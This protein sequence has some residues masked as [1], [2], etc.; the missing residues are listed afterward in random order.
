MASGDRINVGNAYVTIIP[1]LEGAQQS[2][3]EQLGA[4][5]GAAA[6]SVGEQS[7]QDFGNALATGIK[8]TAAVVAAATAAVAG[9]AIATGKAFIQAANDVSEWGNT[10]DKESQKMNMTAEGYQTWAFILEHAG[11]SID[12]MK[13]AMKKLTIAAEEGNDAFDALG[14]SEEQLAAMSPEETWNATIEALQNVADEGERTALAN[15]LLGKGA[16]ELAP[17]FNMTA[18]ETDELK[19][20]VKELG[21]IMS[22]DAVKAAAEYQD[23]LQNMNVALDGVKNN[24][25][26]KFLPGMSQVMKGLSMVFSGQ[27]GIEEIKAGLGE[28]TANIV[29][30]SPEFFEIASAIVT[31]VL[32]GFGAMLPVAASSIFG[33]ISDALVTVTG[34]LPSLLPV[35]TTGISTLMSTVLDCLPLITSSL[36]TLV[37][38]L[39]TWL[40]S[41][42]NVKLLVDGIV[43]LVGA[44]VSQ[45][46]LVLPV[47]L[48]AVVSIIGD[49][50]KCL[51]TPENLAIL[52]NAVLLCVGA[53]IQALVNVVP[54]FIDYY[55]G[56]V[57]NIADVIIG[58]TNWVEPYVSQGL[59]Y[60]LGLFNSWGS[61][62][63]SFFS[64]IVSTITSTVSNWVGNISATISNGIS[65]IYN[66]V[67]GWVGNIKAAIVNFTIGVYNTVTGWIYDIQNGFINGFNSITS[68]VG[69]ILGSIGQFVGD[70]VSTLSSLPGQIVSIGSDMAEG[71]INGLDV[72]WVVEQVKKLGKKAIKALK[73]TLGIASPSKEFEKIGY[74][75]ALGFGGGWSDEMDIIADDMVDGMTDLT[76]SMSAE[77]TAY[78]AGGAATIGDTTTYNGGAV[79][80]NIYGAEGQDVN[81]L[82]DV[83]AEKLGDMTARK[84]AVYA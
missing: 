42:N 38:D 69:N 45:I 16:V 51:T 54:E 15:E 32:E 24:M 33:F 65:G 26:S 64:G 70:V 47:L 58:F 37:T 41:G 43:K 67:T 12:G 62:I 57:T 30:L 36:L 83:I 46:G 80:M 49:V 39:V 81:E 48:P 22:D 84:G 56:L 35:I 31:S 6:K 76:G 18:E 55:V 71:L 1:S 60:V 27:G 77:V 25:M 40:A 53:V 66:T 72:D 61:S 19:T 63:K 78:G 79:T 73:E 10:V 44:V 14:I 74:F 7:G 34:L 59:N 17:L 28:I 8:A 9:A 3:S 21:G 11:A 13:N 23:E 4:S 52:L 50:A 20:Q 29:E 5:A 75:S 82:A 2:I 68:W